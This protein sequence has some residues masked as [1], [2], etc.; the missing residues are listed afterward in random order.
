MVYKTY[1]R[2]ATLDLTHGTMGGGFG[3]AQ[4]GW[5]TTNCLGQ[6]L[7]GR[8]GE[9][10]VTSDEDRRL[11]WWSV[12]DKALVQESRLLKAGIYCICD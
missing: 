9:Y 2:L 4:V 8:D 6:M 7:L 10:F 3:I 1:F 11:S 12:R 5:G